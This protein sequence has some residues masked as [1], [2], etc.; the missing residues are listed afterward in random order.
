VSDEPKGTRE[1][2]KK[3]KG[4]PETRDTPLGQEPVQSAAETSEGSGVHTGR[5]ADEGQRAEIE[6]E[7]AEKQA[8]GKEGTPLTI[9][10][11]GASA[12]GLE[13]FSRLLSYLPSDT[14]LALVFVQHLAS[15]HES[16]LPHLLAS[17]TRMSVVQASE[18]LELEADTV[19]V[20]PPGVHLEIHNG[21]FHLL[22]RPD[23]EGM[24]MPV[25]YFFHS[26]AGYAQ[27]KAVGV[28][29]SGT[30]SDGADGL[31]EIKVQG[32]ITLAQTPTSAKYD[33][34][35]R[36]AIA[37]GAVDMELGLQELAKQLTHL[38]RHPFLR[39]RKPRHTGEDMM[40]SDRQM[41][42]I[43]AR[44]RNAAGVDFTHY[45]PGTIKRRLQRRMLLNRLTGVDSYL[46][47]LR[48]HPPEV[49]ALYQ[50]VLI[51]VTR[52]FREPKSFE[53]LREVVLPR[54]LE[55]NPETIRVWVP[56]CS[57]GEEAYSVAMLLLE[58]LD[59]RGNNL[60]IQIFGTD[61]SEEA[62]EQ[63]RR[64]IFPESIAAD[65]DKERLRR[66]FSRTDGNYRIAKNVR[67][68]CVFARQDITRDPPFSNLDLVLC[69]NLL[70]YL[71]ATVQKKVLG[72][73][74][75]ALCTNGFLMLGSAESTGPNNDLFVPVDK[76]QRIYGKRPVHAPPVSFPLEYGPRFEGVRPPF[77]QRLQ[78][79][80]YADAERLLLDI[81]TPAAV[82]VNEDLSIVHTRGKTGFYL[83]LSAGTPNLNLLK[84]ARRGLLHG[85]R[86]ALH[87]V[88]RETRPTRREGLKVSFNGQG[89]VVDLAVYPLAVQE[90]RHYLVAFED[91]T[92][93]QPP[94]PKS[95]GE[96]SLPAAG[97]DDG[98]A[99]RI[100]VLQEELDSNR[101]YLQATI[102]DLEAA[103][104]ELQSANEEILS[105]NEELQSTNEELDTAKEELQSTN[106]E[107]NTVNEELHSRNEE[108][109]LA[110]SDL[111]N[112]LGSV[113]IAIVMV[114][115]DL[116]IR[117]ITPMAERVLNLRIGDLDRPISHIRPNVE[118]PDLEKMIAGVIDKVEPVER[119]VRD[120]DGR[121]YSLRVRPYKSLDQRIEGAVLAL[122]DIHANKRQAIELQEAHRYAEAILECVSQ[123][124]LVLDGALRVR[125]ANPE[126][127]RHFQVGPKETEGRPISELGNGQWDIPELR[128]LL[129]Q[130]L[131]QR[132]IIDGFQ[133]EH[134]FPH[135]G[136]RVMVL[137]ARAIENADDG[138]GLILLAI[139]DMTAADG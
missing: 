114:S 40:V 93:R 109:S 7:T 5:A 48:Q 51:H 84:M 133:M 67:D 96:R 124:V 120:R 45:K 43:F 82:I 6:E 74:H 70:I 35:P 20:I 138:I 8:P 12:G 121:W 106:E 47:Y 129:D 2:G 26:L 94:E 44:L 116:R 112:L 131:P 77:P 58:V 118:V 60:T 4:E 101:D 98:C 107:L 61:V 57:T 117:R 33:G 123:P 88:R 134:E 122:V 130:V 56:G 102:Q 139:R 14:G 36:A 65:V 79:G 37:T 115:T 78:A 111:S 63:A 103:N 81:Y 22:P 86:S 34:M 73:V 62:V 50:D 38:A 54:L 21:R 39:H 110:N 16:A 19:Y 75:Y 15:H 29:L 72:I 18:D 31:R 9:V 85:L 87:E 42:E 69:R 32:G 46:K 53:A 52:F 24:F 76:K 95:E 49:D 59:E 23:G 137:C 64:G 11:V 100:R 128:K 10:G 125:R 91:V 66:F 30:A 71:D 104:E 3:R 83:E 113:D 105:S 119:E 1:G 68:L 89:R 92:E 13:A 132:R 28:I 41:A 25:D 99:K 127:L 136:R 135:I 17:A 80:P 126:F 90:Q 55:R 97:T 108:L 27:E